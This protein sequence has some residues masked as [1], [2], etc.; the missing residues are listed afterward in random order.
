MHCAAV[1]LF[2]LEFVYLGHSCMVKLLP[3]LLL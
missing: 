3:F 1:S 2:Y